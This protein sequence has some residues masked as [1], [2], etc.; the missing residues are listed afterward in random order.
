M[1]GARNTAVALVAALAMVAATSDAM[2]ADIAAGSSD[3]SAPEL[4][5]SG[6]SIAQAGNNHTARVDQVADAGN[7]ARIVQRGDGHSLDL[8]QSGSG[9]VFVAGQDGSANRI[10]ALQAGSAWAW[11]AQSGSGNSIVLT[12]SAPQSRAVVSQSGAGHSATI[13]QR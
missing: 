4:T 3:L 5:L 2:A 7:L 8:R 12:Q 1:A 6:V 9:N 10:A 13:V 11:L